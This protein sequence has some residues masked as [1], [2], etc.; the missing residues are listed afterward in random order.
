MSKSEDYDD[1]L[2]WHYE[3]QNAEHPDR[4]SSEL[5]DLQKKMQFAEKAWTRKIEVW[6]RQQDIHDTERDENV[7]L[8]T[9]VIFLQ[10]VDGKIMVGLY[11][12][13]GSL[14]TADGSTL[15]PSGFYVRQS[16]K[17][18]TLLADLEELVNDPHVKERDLQDFFERN[19]SLLGGKDYG[20]VIPQACITYND[21]RTWLAD[22][23]LCPYDQTAFHKILEIKLPQLPTIRRKLFGH[24]RFYAQLH[25]ATYQVR[26]YA[27]A[28]DDS[29][30]RQRF[31]DRYGQEVYKPEAE[32]I[33]GRRTEMELIRSKLTFQWRNNVKITDWDT[34]IDR[35]SRQLVPSKTNLN[36]H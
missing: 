36:C 9:N 35:M 16:E 14:A 23:I 31:A 25:Q 2:R 29:G 34:Y 32:V 24:D 19:P 30:V 3:L 13:D 12:T 10:V 5:L 4:V 7:G 15:L 22:F 33:I 27:E 8:L 17:W 11:G 1:Y 20:V 6:D 18:R 28:F 21:N 26:D